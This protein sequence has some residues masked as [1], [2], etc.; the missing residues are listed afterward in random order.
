MKINPFY[1]VLGFETNGY[2]VTYNLNHTSIYL[3]YI[4]FYSYVMFIIKSISICDD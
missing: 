2:Y 4:H 3:I 1:K